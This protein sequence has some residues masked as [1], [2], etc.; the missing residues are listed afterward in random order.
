LPKSLTANFTS[1]CM[2]M[3]C[4]YVDICRTS[5]SPEIHE[6]MMKHNYLSIG[7]DGVVNNH[8]RPVAQVAGNVEISDFKV[9]RKC[10]IHLLANLYSHGFNDFH[11]SVIFTLSFIFVV[12]QSPISGNRFGTLLPVICRHVEYGQN[13]LWQPRR[14][15]E[16]TEYHVGVSQT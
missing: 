15:S 9:E 4:V 6:R 12:H 13:R 1:I 14:Q 3:E 16:S 7:C 8:C 11:P 2:C 5:C 10:L